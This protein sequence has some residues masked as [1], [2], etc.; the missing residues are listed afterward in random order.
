VIDKDNLLDEQER[1]CRE[2]LDQLDRFRA[3]R[4][5]LDLLVYGAA[6]VHIKAD[7]TATRICPLSIEL[8]DNSTL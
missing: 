5:L 7:G 3:E 6:Y 8:A 1:C 2:H 4:T